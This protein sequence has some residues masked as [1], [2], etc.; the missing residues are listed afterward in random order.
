M[1][2]YFPLAIPVIKLRTGTLEIQNNLVIN[3]P[4]AP[5]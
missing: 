5:K 1:S 3:Q 2:E 4:W